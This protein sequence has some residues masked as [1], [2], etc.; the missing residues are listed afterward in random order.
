[1]RIAIVTETY[2][3]EINAIALTVEKKVAWLRER[4]HRVSLIR[5]RQLGEAPRD[6]RD[7]LLTPSSPIPLRRQLRF[8]WPITSRLR[9]RWR[10]ARP[11]LVHVVTEGPLG[12]SAVGAA[13]DLGV[14]VTSDFGTCFH[15]NKREYGAAYGDGPGGNGLGSLAPLVSAYLRW[16]H[17]R[18][19]V[20]F[21]PTAALA[22]EL[23][24]QGI[25]RV[26]ESGRGVDT[27]RF[28][29]GRRSNAL[30]AAW[31]A[32]SD[33]PVVLH[34]GRLA[35]EKNVEVVPRTFALLK[36]CN[37]QARLVWVGD[38]SLR[39]RL[40]AAHPDAVF[41]GELRGDALAVAY[42]SADLLL[43]PSETE[44]FGNVTLEALAS[45]LVVVAYDQAAAA[46]HIESGVNGFLVPPGMTSQFVIAGAMAG[47]SLGECA[48]MRRL[49][50]DAA[51]QA[52]WPA[53]LANF[54]SQ[55]YTILAKANGYG[56]RRLAP[57][58][59]LRL[60]EELLQR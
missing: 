51:M 53:V 1:M 8:G 52:S 54:E 9:A 34:V 36:E 29:P 39:Q 57:Q 4:G 55:L 2:P 56:Y 12:A 19:D 5:P 60:P 20:T 59:S 47:T 48:P 42:A 41:M 17:N 24:A 6:D 45:G 31:G 50:R 10:E 14:Q 27:Q 32:T 43:F 33:A 38:G 13:R 46:V 16:F 37:P 18:T 26:V 58:P 7:T 44:T 21:A 11:D 23:T 40:E 25:A 30:R 15:S 3:P 22:G 49:A 28:S 35:P